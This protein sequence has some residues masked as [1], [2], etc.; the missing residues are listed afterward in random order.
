MN[1]LTMVIMSMIAIVALNFFNPIS[2]PA[3]TCIQ[4]P[5]GMVGWWPG[6]GDADD[7]IGENHGELQ[8]GAGFVSGKVGQ[9]FSFD[10]VDDF[11]QVPDSDLWAFGS[12]D[13][14]ID[15]WANF[16]NNESEARLISNDEG[17]GR[18]NKWF[19]T[20][21]TQNGGVLIF[22]VNGPHLGSISLVFAPFFPIIDQWHH[23]AIT[24]SGNTFTVFV[25]GS[26]V[27]FEVYSVTIPNPNAPLTIGQAEG[28][29]F[30]DGFID[31]VGIFD[32]ALSEAEIQAIYNAGN[33]GKCRGLEV[34]IDIKPGSSPNCINI[35]GHGVIPVAILG[36]QDLEVDDIDTTT[37]SLAGLS[38]RIRGNKGPLCS[39]E[40]S[41]DDYFIDLVCHFEDE[42]NE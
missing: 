41:N 20:W 30:M 14:T 37:L 9:A 40:Y 19:F 28:H 22:H 32:R 29:R 39:T 1:R 38:V 33:A 6:D 8:N 24:R 35:N 42:P 10:G 27:G 11:V 4:A 15:L 31:E 12:N 5:D 21:G 7:Y 18:K 26:P 23:L 2:L 34:D 13:F 36:S 3:Q 17:L 16:Q 25:D